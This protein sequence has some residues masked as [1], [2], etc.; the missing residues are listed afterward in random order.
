MLGK[1]LGGISF[2]VGLLMIILFPFF[3]RRIQVEGMS[4]GGVLIGGILMLIGLYFIF[5]G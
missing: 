1:I 3:D 4:R 2:V 5:F